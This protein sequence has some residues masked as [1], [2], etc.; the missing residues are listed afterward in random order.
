MYLCA[1][2]AVNAASAEMRGILRLLWMVPQ[3]VTTSPTSPSDA[4][5]TVVILRD[6]ESQLFLPIWIF[7][8]AALEGV[9]QGRPPVNPQ[10]S[11]DRVRTWEVLTTLAVMTLYKGG[12]VVPF[13][14]YV[15]DPVNNYNQEV[16][17]SVDYFVTNNFIVNVGQRY[18]INTTSHPVFETWGVA[19]ANRGRSE[20]Q[21]RFTYQ[22]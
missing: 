15:L 8:F 17:W 11:F 4:A 20:T 6:T 7:V 3:C 14:A 18:F 9:M 22:F 16:F 21:V 5:G 13:I 19:G 12:S 2:E 10:G 1:L